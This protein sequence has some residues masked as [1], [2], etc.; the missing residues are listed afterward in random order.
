VA[1]TVILAAVGLPLEAVGLLLVTDR[2]L[3]MMRTTVN[4]YSDTC[5]AV[6]VAR[7]EKEELPMIR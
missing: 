5:G 7:S 1:I 2:I 3:D 4:V 6:I